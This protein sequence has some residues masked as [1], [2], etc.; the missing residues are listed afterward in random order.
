MPWTSSFWT[1]APGTPQ[2]WWY[3]LGGQDRRAQ[4]ATGH[5][6]NPGGTL[7]VNGQTKALIF[8]GTITYWVT[9]RN[10]GGFTTNFNLQGGTLA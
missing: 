5:P 8:D 9:A 4:F 10:I 7:Q 6:L 1:I 3:S 2:R